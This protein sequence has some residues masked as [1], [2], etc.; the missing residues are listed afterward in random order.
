MILFLICEKDNDIPET[1]LLKDIQ[2]VLHLCEALIKD[3]NLIYDSQNNI[4]L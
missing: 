2:I 3:Y 4:F 1:D